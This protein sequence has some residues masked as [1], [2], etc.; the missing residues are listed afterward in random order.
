MFEDFVWKVAKTLSMVF[1]SAARR[2][3]HFLLENTAN[4][5]AKNE[6]QVQFRA[7]LVESVLASTLLQ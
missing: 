3:W 5:D 2:L 7:T 4:T 6:T 1:D